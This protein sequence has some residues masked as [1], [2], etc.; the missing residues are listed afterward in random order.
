ME[1][2][3][4]H[5]LHT[6]I[7]IVMV[8]VV[9]GLGFA[10]WRA[11]P[12]LV[13][14]A[15]FGR[16]LRAQAVILGVSAERAETLEDAIRRDA[17]DDGIPLRRE[18]IEVDAGASPPQVTADYSVP[19]DLIYFRPDIHFHLQ[20]PKKDEVF[21]LFDRV[22]LAGAGLLAGVFW[23]FQGFFIFR[24]YRLVADTP[25]V[26]IRSMAMGRVQIRGK[27]VGD[28][29]LSS[30]VSNQ[31]CYLYKV[32]IDRW[33]EGRSGSGQWSAYLT[34]TGSVDFYLEDETGKVRVESEGAECEL[35]SSDQREISRDSAVPLGQAWQDD[36]QPE[37]KPGFPKTDREVRDYV[38][39]VKLGMDTALFQGADPVSLEGR[40]GKRKKPRRP[41]R[42]WSGGLLGG[43]MA[44]GELEGGF[45]H[46]AGDLRL[47][48]YC[49]VPEASYDITGTCSLNSKQNDAPHRQIIGKGPAGS[50]FLIS[51]QSGS[52]LKESLRSR[53]RSRIL[54]GGLLT[55][56][57]AAVLLEAMGLL[58]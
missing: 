47:T 52:E 56:A 23:F 27:A 32:D 42:N 41:K 12:I 16:D 46:V 50:L 57:C 37:A 5:S 9:A 58:V 35:E 17:E 8:L 31:P 21:T 4:E 26:P 44:P 24:E 51:N 11:L 28:K 53:A 54:G 40:G 7:T 3:A 6:A 18:D 10:G 55:L 1:T 22:V 48:E 20:Y 49:I 43:L 33:Q 38:R 2:E 34:D 19:L 15:K 39:R 29:T 30:P 36:E 45:N 25:I 13:S 14:N